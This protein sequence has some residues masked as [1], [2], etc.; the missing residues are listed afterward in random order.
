MDKNH[1]NNTEGEMSDKHTVRKSNHRYI[2]LIIT[3]KDLKDSFS[4]TSK[5]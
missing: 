4:S 2:I 3:M 5:N 1:N